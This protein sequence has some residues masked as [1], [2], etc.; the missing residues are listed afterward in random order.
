MITK[1]EVENG[2][3]VRFPHYARSNR[4]HTSK[5]YP[6]QQY[7]ERNISHSPELQSVVA[8]PTYHGPE[9]KPWMTITVDAK[10]GI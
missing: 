7:S 8:G 5:M 2:S 9:V 6:A 10:A 4:E 3:C 1:S